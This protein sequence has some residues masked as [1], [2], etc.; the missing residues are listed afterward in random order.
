MYL[1]D[2]YCVKQYKFFSYA[3]CIDTFV[4]SIMVESDVEHLE[5]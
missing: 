1:L 3:T 4:Y 2:V 5:L